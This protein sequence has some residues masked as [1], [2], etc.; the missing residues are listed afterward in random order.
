MPM[1]SPDAAE[2]IL[3]DARVLLVGVG[4][5][6]APAAHA[7]AASGVGTLGLIDPDVVEVS[8]LHRQPLYTSRD[9]GV[10]KVTAA[11]ER[12][13][14][15]APGLVLE[16]W[17]ERFGPR[18]LSLLRTFDLVIDGT[19][20]I[21]A[22]FVVNDVAV[23]AGVPLIHAAVLGFRV[24]LLS[25]LPRRSACYRCVF[26]EPP[27]P[28]DVPSC[29]QAGV[30]GPVAVLAGTLAAAEAIRLAEGNEA[31]LADRLL[32]IDIRDGRWRT[33]PLERNSR[34]AA[35]A[36]DETLGRSDAP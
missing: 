21:E 2:S 9:V 30:L 17:R 28:G 8:N 29:E 16:T 1:D 22:K 31:A 11:A 24:Q 13:R 33:V 19:D 18:H 7:L 4:G 6:G 12:L 27:P 26:E 32:T 23:A 15:L 25:V 5:I 20:S 10:A 14:P 3:H 34:C 36:T 35:C